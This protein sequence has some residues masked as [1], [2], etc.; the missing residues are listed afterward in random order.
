VKCLATALQVKFA[1][2]SKLHPTKKQHV[3]LLAIREGEDF[4]DNFEYD[5]IGTPCEHVFKHGLTYYPAQVQKLFPLDHWLQEKHI[6]SYLAVAVY[7]DTGDPIGHL[8][9]MHD[10]PLRQDLPAESV[11]RAFAASA[12]AEL[13]RESAKATRGESE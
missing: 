7:D 11:L 8:G 6:E 2:L 12:G 13:C 9:I 10:L 5:I 3:R 4:S 1:F